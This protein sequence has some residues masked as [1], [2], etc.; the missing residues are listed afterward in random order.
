MYAAPIAEFRNSEASGCVKIPV[1]P[2]RNHIN[3]SRLHCLRTTI[4]F[5]STSSILDAPFVTI[6][7]AGIRILKL[8]FNLQ[9]RIQLR[10]VVRSAGRIIIV[11]DHNRIR[12][13]VD[14]YRRCGIPS[15]SVIALKISHSESNFIKCPASA[16]VA[17]KRAEQNGTIR[18]SRWR[19]RPKITYQSRSKC[20]RRRGHR[21]HR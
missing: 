18:R 14:V 10:H 7:L 6:R 4:P 2:C 15:K 12:S 3:V 5:T 11:L 13:V 17:R 19:R 9:A 1:F 8:P 21:K 16:V 20:A